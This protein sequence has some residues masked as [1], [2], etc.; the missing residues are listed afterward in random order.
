M[1]EPR[2]LIFLVVLVVAVVSTGFVTRRHQA[3]EPGEDHFDAAGLSSTQRIE[4]LERR[5]SMR[6]ES[7]RSWLSRGIVIVVVIT[8]VTS[9]GLQRAQH[10]A[11]QSER[12]SA[13]AQS[14]SAEVEDLF[15]RIDRV[16]AQREV[17]ACE[18]RNAFRRF[19]RGLLEDLQAEPETALIVE[20]RLDEYNERFPVIECPEP[21]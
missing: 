18:T 14:A 7:G 8:I 9:I 13:E 11:H 5:D 3:T 20:E 15:R 17:D 1:P 16:T 19:V 21:P 10:A 6:D 12:A 2:D 4:R